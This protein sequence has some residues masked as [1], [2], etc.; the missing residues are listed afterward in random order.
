MVEHA[1]RD[2]GNPTRLAPRDAARLLV[3]AH[4]AVTGKRPPLELLELE[5]SQLWLETDRTRSAWFFNFG[6]ITPGRAW[7]GDIWRPPWFLLEDATTDRHRALHEKMLAGQ[8]PDSFRAYGS[9]EEGMRDY[10]RTLESPR[11]ESMRVAGASGD[12]EAFATAA[13]DSFCP[14]CP[15]SFGSSLAAMRDEL[16]GAGAFAGLELR[17]S[18]SSSSGLGLLAVAIAAWFLLRKHG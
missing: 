13:R 9:A 4:E 2:R 12:A 15:A 5:L 17:R 7:R 1:W 14:D 6:N 3:E 11:R 8:A 16:R 10:V 18:S